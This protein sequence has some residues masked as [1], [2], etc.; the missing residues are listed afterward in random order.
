MGQGSLVESHLMTNAQ[1][2]MV[3]GSDETFRL[4]ESLTPPPATHR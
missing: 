4:W 3:N 1:W 2:N